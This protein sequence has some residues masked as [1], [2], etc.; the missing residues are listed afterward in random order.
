MRLSFLTIFLATLAMPS[1]SIAAPTSLVGLE[2]PPLPAGCKHQESMVL[3]A[4]DAFAYERL[5]CDDREVV[6]LQ[7]FVE[8]R[9]KL[10]Y[11]KV[12][13]ELRLP[14]VAHG[15][16]L[17]EVPLCSSTSHK[18]EA[19]LAIGKWETAQDGSFVAKNISYAWRFN[20]LSKK[21]ESISTRGVSCEGDNPD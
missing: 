12:I 9:G 14:P 15:Q 7:R 16:V 17:L 3:G 18:D 13:D 6:V 11:W 19:I 4:S 20:L 10:A 21:I 2:I 8:R 1:F 5:L